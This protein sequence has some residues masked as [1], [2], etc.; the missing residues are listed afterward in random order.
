MR[1]ELIYK[2]VKGSCN[3]CECDSHCDKCDIEGS[4]F[5][6][7][8]VEKEPKEFEGINHCT[9]DEQGNFTKCEELVKMSDIILNGVQM[10]AEEGKY[11]FLPNEEP[12][13]IQTKYEWKKERHNLLLNHILNSSSN[14]EK[15]SCELN[16]IRKWLR[17]NKP[18]KWE[19]CTNE[20]TKVGD[21]IRRIDSDELKRKVILILNNINHEFVLEYPELDIQHLHFMCNYEINTIAGDKE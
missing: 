18:E 5:A 15:Q 11:I 3:D 21:T 17:E 4:G 16:S 6:Y 14:T 8:F 20:N 19:T 7:E 2:K 10:I 9:A 1:E 13:E 12:K